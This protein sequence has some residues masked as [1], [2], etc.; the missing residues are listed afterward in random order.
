MLG[1]EFN[2]E[3]RTPNSPLV[4]ELAEDQVQSLDLLVDGFLP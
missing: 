1:Q 2:S 3:G 4:C